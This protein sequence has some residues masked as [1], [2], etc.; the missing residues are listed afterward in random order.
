MQEYSERVSRELESYREDRPELLHPGIFSYWA[1]THLSPRLREVMETD[2]IPRFFAN[3]ILSGLRRTAGANIASIGCGDC[4]TEIEVANLLLADGAG[5]FTF[6][7]YDIS[8]YQL[9][10]APRIA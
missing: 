6:H 10:R 5:D 8:P 2:S 7:C 3:T 9:E 1:G 4:G